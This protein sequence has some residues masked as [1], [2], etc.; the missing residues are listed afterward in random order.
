[1]TNE[2]AITR[3]LIL[4][5][6]PAEVWDALTNPEKTKLFM[7]HAEAESEWQ[8]GS[9][10]TWTGTGKKGKDFRAKGA[11]II[12]QRNVQLKYTYLELHRGTEDTSRNYLHVTFD[13][14][15]KYKGTELEIT[16]ENFNDDEK[17]CDFIAKTWDN[18]VI[19]GLKRLYPQED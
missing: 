12:S 19:P 8:V 13:L 16:I 17:R 14:K 3:Q 11:V 5:A 6:P 18:T 1:M 4:N 10:I 2:D 7:F 9:P 15:G